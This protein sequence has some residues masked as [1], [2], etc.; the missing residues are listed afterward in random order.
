MKAKKLI[1]VVPILLLISTA[2]GQETNKQKFKKLEW[3]VG[4]WIRA[5]PAAGQSGYETWTKINGLK[6]S[7]KGVTLKGKETIFL[8]NLEFIVKGNDIFY[9]VMI[10]GEK[11]PTYFKLTALSA[12]GFTCE[13]TKHDFPKKI[14]YQRDGK[15]VKAVISG[16]GQSMDYNFVAASLETLKL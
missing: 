8:E 16:N 2:F 1:L 3:L 10:T 11:Q 7:G 4:K 13:N 5:N 6:L 15:Y 14:T 9:S 12:N